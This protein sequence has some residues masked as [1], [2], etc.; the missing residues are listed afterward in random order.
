MLSFATARRFLAAAIL[1]VPVLSVAPRP[2]FAEE[3]IS[4]AAAIVND[5]VISTYDLEQ[6][7]NL[8][9]MSSGA[10]SN[11]DTRARVRDQVLRQLIDEMLQLQEAQELE[12]KV[13]REDIEKALE[14]IAQQNNTTVE[15]VQATLKAN[16]VD[17]A[18]LIVQIQAELAWGKLIN[19]RLAPRINVSDEEIDLVY[20]RIA[21]NAERRQFQ[22]SEIFISV[23]SEED[24]PRVRELLGQIY[25]AMQ[26]GAPFAAIARQYS[27][28]SSA[29][30]GGDIGWVSEGQLPENVEDVLRQLQRG[31]V[32]EPIRVV[33]GYYIMALR[34]RRDRAGAPTEAPPPMPERPAGVP[35]GSVRLMRV[36]MQIPRDPSQEQMAE[37]QGRLRGLREAIRGCQGL[38]DVVKQFPRTSAQ[39]FGVIRLADMNADYRRL[40]E[41]LKPSEVSQPFGTS[42]GIEMLVVCGDRPMPVVF[43]STPFEMPTREDIGERLFNQELSMQARRYM[44]DLRRDAVIEIR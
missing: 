43:E 13:E 17:F 36:V 32:S 11:P 26:R 37:I 3:D 22:V 35:E 6:R 20:N 40:I 28:A 21:E 44:R 4:R 16:S 2:A 14:R 27:E 1:V 7:I 38:S 12:I 18:T 31:Q 25:S 9:L 8:V 41:G 33:G 29:A 5:V 24:E 23:D 42:A 39:S 10:P 30:Q 15:D 19:A 34:D